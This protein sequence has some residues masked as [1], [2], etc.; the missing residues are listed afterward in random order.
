LKPKAENEHHKTRSQ[1]GSPEKENPD[2]KTIMSQ[3]TKY[4]ITVQGRVQGVGFRYH[5]KSVA[6]H[7]G[8]KGSVHN[9]ADGSVAI[10][11]SATPELK[12]F[13]VNQLQTAGHRWINIQQI[14]ITENPNLPDY[15]SFK[16]I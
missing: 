16:I 7:L 8:L 9:Q 12:D 2:C 6:D 10:T 3:E 4:Q 13:F 15:E 14:L 11:I 1:K 5:A